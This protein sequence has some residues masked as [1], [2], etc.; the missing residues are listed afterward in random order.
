MAQ[1]DIKKIQ[2]HY[3][4]APFHFPNRKALKELLLGL[5]K[6]EGFTIEVVNY[7]FCSDD[8]LLKINKAHLNHDTYTDII[9]FEYSDSFESVLSDIYISVERVRE[10]SK[11]YNVF[12][13]KELSRV[14]LHG[15][16]HLCGYNDK[17]K[18]QIAEMRSKEEFYLSGLFHVKQNRSKL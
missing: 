6:K 13:T 17:S 3:L 9:T 8:Y 15:A 2:F 14:V 5:F 16:L 12:F 4:V 10:N 1:K 7:I 11:E 18:Q